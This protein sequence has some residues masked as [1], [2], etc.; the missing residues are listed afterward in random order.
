MQPD[1][2]RPGLLA[3]LSRGVEWSDEALRVR[4]RSTYPPSTLVYYAKKYFKPLKPPDFCKNELL[5]ITKLC[6]ISNSSR[7][8]SVVGA[9]CGA[10]SDPEP[11]A[12]TRSLAPLLLNVYALPYVIMHRIR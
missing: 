12:Y 5:T 3:C 4:L 9:G 11:G 6:Q 7:D 2:I 10:D 8:S 1:T